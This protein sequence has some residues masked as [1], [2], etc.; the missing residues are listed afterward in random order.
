[1][2]GEAYANN[3]KQISLPYNTVLHQ[4]VNISD[5]ILKQILN[6]LQCNYFEM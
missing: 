6:I 1:M 2:H 5:N 4:I 3:L